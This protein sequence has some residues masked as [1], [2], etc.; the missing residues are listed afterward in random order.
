[1]KRS[2]LLDVAA[3]FESAAE[4]ELVCVLEVATDGKS[5][6]DSSDADSERFQ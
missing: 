4:R 5:A 6:R 2:E 3:A 1:L